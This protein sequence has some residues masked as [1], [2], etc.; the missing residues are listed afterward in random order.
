MLKKPLVT[1]TVDRVEA[2]IELC[3]ENAKR[4]LRNASI[5]LDNGGS[6]GLAYVLWSLA[7]EEFGKGQ[8]LQDQIEHARPGSTVSI[9]VS[10]GHGDKFV[11]GFDELP[12][13]HGS[14]VG[15]LLRVTSNVSADDV[16]LDDPLQPGVSVTVAA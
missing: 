4:F 16:V 5:L 2:G 15:W 10:A 13:L 9:D 7:V 6:D 12:E 1:T 14:T 11:R 8:L 3:E